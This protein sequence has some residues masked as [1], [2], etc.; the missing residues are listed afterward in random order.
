MVD[1]PTDRKTVNLVR[2]NDD[3]GGSL[4]LPLMSA[5]EVYLCLNW[6][7]QPLISGKVLEINVH[8]QTRQLASQQ[9][10][11]NDFQ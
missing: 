2:L 8:L 9:A 6:E 4:M 11:V 1:K 5:T 3:D 10:P 7:M